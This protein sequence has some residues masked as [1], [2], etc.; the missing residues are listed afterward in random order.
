MEKR[1]CVRLNADRKVRGILRG[2]DEFMNIVLEDAEEIV[3][4]DEVNELGRVVIRG[5]SVI[6]IESLERIV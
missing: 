3:G 5:N 1:L 2:Y 6:E 4:P